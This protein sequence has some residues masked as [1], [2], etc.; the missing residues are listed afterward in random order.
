MTTT[1]AGKPCGRVGFGMISL[2]HPGCISTEDA[3]EVLKAALESGSNLWNAGERYGTAEYNSLHLIKA[4]FTKYPEDADKVIVT[5]KFCLDSRKGLAFV[6]AE[7]VK[8]AMDRCLAILDGKCRVDVFQPGRLSHDVP[9]EET[10]GALVEYVKAGKIG[11]VGLSECSGESIRKA[12]SVT[13]I[14]LVEVEL[15]LFETGIYHNGVADACKENKIPI[16]AYSPLSRGFL[17][18]QIR[19]HEDM[20]KTDYRHFFPRFAKENFDNNVQLVD[21]ADAVAKQ[22]GCS[23]VQVALAWVCQQKDVIGVPVDP[24][25]G[26]MSIDRLKENS[27]EVALTK[28]E[29]GQLDDVLTNVEIKGARYP[30][31]QQHWLSV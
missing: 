25:P 29:L 4:Y 11:A 8:K 17:N 30:V 9:V 10:V 5:V 6:D 13:P 16:L 21:V 26:T 2:M 20:A 1:I 27:T 12:A 31:S 23:I 15:S 3:V 28:E 14:A 19:K 18:G 22:K 24:I 7:S